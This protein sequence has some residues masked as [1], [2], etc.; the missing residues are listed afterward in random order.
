[1]I[2][3]FLS[4]GMVFLLAIGTAEAAGDALAGKATAAAC[5]GCHGANG[6]GIPPNPA[7]TGKSGDQILQA[8]KDFKSGKRDNP[9]MKGIAAGLSDQDMANLAAYYASLK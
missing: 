1:M 5:A 8:L 3:M 2:R 9:V 4:A 7:L 6:Q